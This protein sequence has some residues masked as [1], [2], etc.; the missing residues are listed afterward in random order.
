MRTRISDF[1]TLEFSGSSSSFTSTLSLVPLAYVTHQSPTVAWISAFDHFGHGGDIFSQPP[2]TF[3]YYIGI[4]F[5]RALTRE[6][7]A[8]QVERTVRV[9]R[10]ED[11]NLSITT[12]GSCGIY[13]ECG[14]YM[15]KHPEGGDIAK[16]KEGSKPLNKLFEYPNPCGRFCMKV[17][18]GYTEHRSEPCYYYFEL[19]ISQSRN[20]DHGVYFVKSKYARTRCTILR[21]EVIVRDPQPVCT[22]HLENEH[23]TLRFSCE[24][25]PRESSDNME[26]VVG[27]QPLPRSFTQTGVNGVRTVI[28]VTFALQDA[29]DI[30]HVPDACVVSNSDLDFQNQ[31]IFSVYMLPSTNEVTENGGQAAFACCTNRVNSQDCGFTMN[32]SNLYHIRQDNS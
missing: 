15:G 10:G 5:L 24:W 31:C 4:T 23:G 17:K 32:F 11:V 2:V 29:F 21:M 13:F 26:L 6:R 30:N 12:Y 1:G 16:S 7:C 25:L 18:R 20:N 8:Q 27:N 19:S 22:T 14:V 9:N 3:L 28:S